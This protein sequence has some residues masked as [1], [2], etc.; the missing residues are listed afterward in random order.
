MKAGETDDKTDPEEVRGRLE[1]HGYTTHLVSQIPDTVFQCH[2]LYGEL[3]NHQ[4]SNTIILLVV[5]GATTIPEGPAR[6]YRYYRNR[7][8]IFHLHC[9]TSSP[10][11]EIGNGN[12]IFQPTFRNN[13]K[14]LSRFSQ[15]S[16]ACGRSRSG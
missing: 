12:K 5:V 9:T 15:S 7:T 13:S 2:A 8:L 3:P 6:N 16:C 1:I 4:Q 14:P 10:F 11:I